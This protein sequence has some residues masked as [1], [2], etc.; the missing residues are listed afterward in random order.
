MANYAKDEFFP[1]NPEKYS[2][3]RPIIYRSSWEMTLMNVF[4]NHPNVLTWQSESLSIPYL[5]PLT[6]KWSMYIPDFLV[7][8][9]DKNNK[10][11]CEIIEVKP[12]KEDYRYVPAV[13]KNG[14]KE[15]ISK[16]TKLKQII[17]MA[18]WKAAAE[19]CARRGW[20]FRVMTEHQL[21]GIPKKG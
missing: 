4:D 18:K 10:Q 20:F 9:I 19:F 5:N 2:G 11:H 1:K 12:A 3:K 7:V 21:F 16:E 6:G 17:N 13:R 8:Y 14:R 15:I